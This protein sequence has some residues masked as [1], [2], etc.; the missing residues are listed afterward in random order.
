MAFKKY[1]LDL[2]TD[3][4]NLFNPFDWDKPSYAFT[5]DEKDMKPYSIINGKDT[6]TIV[7]NV[8]GIDK[9]DLKLS[10]E[11]ENHHIYI[12]IEGKTT[13]EIT[14]KEYTINSRFSVDDSQL[15]MKRIESTMR[16][17][18]LYV[19]IPYKEKDKLEEGSVTIEIK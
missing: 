16:N 11:I 8:L 13:D 5:R 14:G 4:Y 3:F 2:T 7:H 17:G 1:D 18:L 10:K 9:K 12:V 15:N 6:I 19:T